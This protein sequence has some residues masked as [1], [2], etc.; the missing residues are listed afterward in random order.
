VTRGGAPELRRLVCAAFA[1][2]LGGVDLRA[3]TEHAMPRLPR[4]ARAIGVIAVGKAAPA[5]AE[6]ALRADGRIARVLVVAPDGTKADV[7]DP[8]VELLRSAH[9]Y[10]DRRSV[11][12]ARRAVEVARGSDFVVAAVSGGASALM[13]MPVAISLARYARIVRALLLGGAS[14]RDTNVVRRHLC[15][16]KGGGLALA[17][18]G[19]VV[20]LVASDVVGGMPYD[21][22]SGPT[23]ADPT[24]RADAR[25]VLRRFAP[26][27]AVPALRETLKPGAARARELRARIVASPEDLARVVARE[28]RAQGLTV[29]VLPPSIA[30]ANELVSEYAARARRLREG[31]AVVRAA[32]PALRVT[33]VRPGAG[34]RSTHLA[35]LLAAELPPGVVFLA[36]ASDGV[37]GASGT[38]GAVVDRSLA[39]RDAGGALRRALAA[40][41]TGPLVAGAGMALGFGPTGTNLADIHVIARGVG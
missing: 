36:G 33:A 40:F 32:E 20:T 16:I 7:Q 14:V 11:A 39:A 6:G 10:P 3:R 4:S 19:P 31:E 5:M 12:A 25:C 9:P 28:L 23:V 41:D 38:S 34:G 24:T 26:R 18:G 13:C 37:D 17:S 29:R 27:L 8:R 35:A 15:A 2:A 30:P 21:V 22:G 1:R